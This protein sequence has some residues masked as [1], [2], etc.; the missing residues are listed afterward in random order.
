[1]EYM[2][3]QADPDLWM[4]PMV[5]PSDGAYYYAH[6]LLYV[7]GSLCIHHNAESILMKVDKYFKLKSDSV[8]EPDMYL[9]AKVQSSN[10]RNGVWNWALSLS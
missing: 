6:I 3:C 9:G 10:L 8:G 4:K 2:S 5:R 1:M 7:N